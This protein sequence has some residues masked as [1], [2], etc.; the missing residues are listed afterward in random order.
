MEVP[1]DAEGKRGRRER[2]GSAPATKHVNEVCG[3][4]GAARGDDGDRNG[5]RH[6]ACQLAIKTGPG[7]VAVHGG[8]Q[9]LSCSARGRFSRPLHRVSARGRTSAGDEY[10]E[11]PLPSLVV[12]PNHA[13]RGTK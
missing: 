10:P 11:P 12:K 6:K 9:D 4:S 13:R 7:S 5:L 3:R 8:E 1:L 2:G